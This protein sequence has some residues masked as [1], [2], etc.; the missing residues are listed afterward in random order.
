MLQARIA[1]VQTLTAVLAVSYTVGQ[2]RGA[3]DLVVNY[4]APDALRFTALKDTLLS[5]QE[6]FDVLLT[7]TVYQVQTADRPEANLQQGSVHDFARAYPT[8]RTF[9]MVGEAFFVPGVSAPG[10]P[11]RFN[12]AGTRLRTELRHGVQAHWYVKPNTFDIAQACLLWQTED[13]RVLVQVQ[14]QDYRQVEKAYLPHRVTVT[15]RRLGFTA[16]SVVKQLTL[17]LPLAPG[18]FQPMP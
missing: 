17:N 2:Q 18:V 6:L 4:A 7:S 10:Q 8:F 14:Y 13:D 15:D 12:A 9:L 3:F 1:A 11:R 5:T 16:H